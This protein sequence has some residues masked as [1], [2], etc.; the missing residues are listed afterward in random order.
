MPS[1]NG[2]QRPVENAAPSL[3]PNCSGHSG[4]PLKG[5]Q[6]FSSIAALIVR[7]LT[8]RFIGDYEA[9]TGALYSRKFTIDGE[10]ISLQVQDTPFVSLEVMWPLSCR[11]A[12][13]EKV[14]ILQISLSSSLKPSSL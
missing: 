11:D 10:Q 6:F 4:L 13:K 2:S 3:C 8:K 12:S 7:F 14:Y 9:N 1:V 5:L